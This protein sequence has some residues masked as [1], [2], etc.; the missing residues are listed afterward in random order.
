MLWRRNL[1]WTWALAAVPV[2]WML[3]VL[4][5][6]TLLAAGVWLGCLDAAALGARWHRED[7]HHG[8]DIAEAARNRIGLRGLIRS[9][10]H[11]HKIKR[12]G[13]LSDGRLTVGVDVRGLRVQIP[14]GYES[15]S[16]TLVVGATGSGKTVSEAWVAC[17]LI[18]AGHAAIVI[19][20]KGDQLLHDELELAAQHQE[21]GFYEWT[22]EGP[23]AYNPYGTGTAGEIADKAL[24]GEQFTEPHYLRQAQRYLGHAVR[25]MHTAGIPVSPVSLMGQ[26]DPRQL[27]VTARGLPEGIAAETQAY[28]DG[29]TERQRRELAGVRDRLSILA[30]SDTRHWL[31]P[32]PE[33]GLLDILQAVQERA[34]VYFRLDSDRR[35]LLAAMLA[36]AIVSDPISL[37]A[38]LQADP[39]ATVVVIDEFSAVAAEH[40]ARLFARARSAGV[41]LILGTQELAD[42][43]GVG[44]GL[45]GSR[46]SGTSR[47]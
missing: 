12:N 16:Y 24:S 6:A 45:C 21:T 2:G 26:L 43:K 28:L 44:R 5:H 40:V 27:E 11:H 29:L 39:V 19:D 18:G 23:W 15:G 31:H 42:L 34:V 36:A 14:V 32:N 7:L 30:E 25:A 17:R 1:R 8:A 4:L 47:P 37:A 46:R 3:F 20:P 35:P 9:H 38:R 33:A 10:L 41:S 13:W 22:P